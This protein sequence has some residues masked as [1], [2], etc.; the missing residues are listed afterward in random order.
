MPIIKPSS[1]Y[2]VWGVIIASLM[3][4]MVHVFAPLVAIMLVIFISILGAVVLALIE[5][6][7]EPNHHIGK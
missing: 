3:N 1:V 2:Y 7:L 4:I 5:M 6:R